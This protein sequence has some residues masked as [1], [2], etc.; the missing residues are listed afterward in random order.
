VVQAQSKI[1]DVPLSQT[2]VLY[3]RYGNSIARCFWLRNFSPQNE[4]TIK[5]QELVAGNWTDIDDQIVLG[6][7]GSGT[8]QSTKLITSTNPLRLL[9]SGGTNDRDLEVAV[10]QMFDD[11]Q[12]TAWASPLT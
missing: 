3:L 4:I 5:F 1:I 6:V 7:P 9:A 10:A 2:T 8:E 11:S 12:T